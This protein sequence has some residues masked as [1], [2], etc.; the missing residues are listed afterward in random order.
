[1]QRLLE[2]G[3]YLKPEKCEFHKNSEVIG[4]D[5]NQPKGFPWTRI[6]V[7]TDGIE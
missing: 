7:E 2:A 6:K 3:L 5:Y 1:M 4:I